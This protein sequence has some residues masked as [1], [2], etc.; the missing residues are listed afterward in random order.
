MAQSPV[1]V[2]VVDSVGVSVPAGQV[3]EVAVRGDTVMRGYWENPSATAAA[4]RDGWL[5]T[6]DVGVF[7]SDGFLTQVKAVQSTVWS[8][9]LRVYPRL[10]MGTHVARFYAQFFSQKIPCPMVFHAANPSVLMLLD[11]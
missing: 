1:L 7:D 2:R 5:L 6:G 4:V 10:V 3:G 9:R 11:L 8:D